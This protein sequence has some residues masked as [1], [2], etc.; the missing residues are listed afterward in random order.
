MKNKSIG[1]VWLRDAVSHQ[2]SAKIDDLLRLPRGR[3]Y[4]CFLVMFAMGQGL[5]SVWISLPVYRQLEVVK[6]SELTLTRS[7]QKIAPKLSPMRKF[8]IREL[9]RQI[10]DGAYYQA[11]LNVQTSPARMAGLL[12]EL[13]ALASQS[14][15]VVQRLR[16]G[17]KRKLGELEVMPLEIDVRGSYDQLGVF[18]QNLAAPQ[19]GV[20]I[21][22]AE[23]RPVR[24]HAQR[25]RLHLRAFVYLFQSRHQP[26]HSRELSTSRR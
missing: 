16:W 4:W 17:D 20:A 22:S 18:C 19:L 12:N 21:Q 8:Q 15:L 7:V 24:A 9:G 2:F 1:G 11:M 23:L 26:D 6:A 13:H 10:H 3:R 25:L 14:Q 5:L